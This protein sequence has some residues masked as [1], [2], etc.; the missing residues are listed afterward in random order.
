M[1]RK[2]I[3]VLF[4]LLT[5]L[6]GCGSV[7]PTAPVSGGIVALQVHSDG[8]FSLMNDTSLR[9]YLKLNDGRIVEHKWSFSKGT[10]LTAVT[11]KVVDALRSDGFTVESIPELGALRIGFVPGLKE[12]DGDGFSDYSTTNIDGH[13]QGLG[14]VSR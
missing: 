4:G 5:T 10:E 3:G 8:P 14:Y 1:A 2:Q 11:E 7:Q 12:F 6:A 9:V 13:L